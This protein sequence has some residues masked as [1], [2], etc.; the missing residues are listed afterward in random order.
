MSGSLHTQQRQNM[1]DAKAEETIELTTAQDDAEAPV[2]KL[3]A[4]PDASIN[5]SWSEKYQEWR[6]QKYKLPRRH[7]L[8][9]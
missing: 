5:S 8:S 9:T 7:L 1:S 3:A 2:E 4:E 6:S